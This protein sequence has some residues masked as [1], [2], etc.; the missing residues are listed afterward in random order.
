MPGAAK[1]MRHS[2][3]R[4]RLFP[5]AVVGVLVCVWMALADIGYL[6]YTWQ[7]I[8]RF[9]NEEIWPS[10][11]EQYARSVIWPVLNDAVDSL[12]AGKEFSAP[13]G[14]FSHDAE[15]PIEDSYWMRVANRFA[16][17]G[18]SILPVVSYW[19]SD[20]EAAKATTDTFLRRHGMF[21]QNVYA[22][23]NEAIRQ[24]PQQSA[25][26]VVWAYV[27]FEHPDTLVYWPGGEQYRRY[28]LGA[29]PSLKRSD[30]ALRREWIKGKLSE[31]RTVEAATGDS[32]GRG[33]TMISTRSFLWN[34]GRAI[35]AVDVQWM[36]APLG[37]IMLPVLAWT[38][39]FVAALLGFVVLGVLELRRF[40]ARRKEA[41]GVAVTVD[42]VGWSKISSAAERFRVQ[43][44][45]EDL[46]CRALRD[47]AGEASLRWFTGD[48]FHVL[49]STAWR[50]SIYRDPLTFVVR[51][52]TCWAEAQLT[53]ENGVPLEL[54]S[55]IG[56]HGATTM[57]RRAAGWYVV[58]D[59]LVSAVRIDEVSKPNRP[60]SRDSAV[61]ACHEAFHREL[62]LQMGA[63]Y[64]ELVESTSEVQQGHDKQGIQHDYRWLHLRTS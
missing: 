29:S 15:S 37:A 51:L 6:A 20:R 50:A 54:R 28:L 58:G 14:S 60:P 36:D 3:I 30:P 4:G 35:L 7:W 52:Q 42:I 21:L 53:D 23:V 16:S 55:S 44:V 26:E 34:E 49:F 56:C 18:T 63:S 46:V 47:V 2:R 11:Q 19:G 27:I 10:T 5:W 41:D 17:F 45:L 39:V 32:L 64:D 43:F 40:F 33:A 8:T 13:P 61:V 24:N 22:R 9:K 25:P 48:G 1:I 59:R 31:E 62:K 12:E 57:R 38:G